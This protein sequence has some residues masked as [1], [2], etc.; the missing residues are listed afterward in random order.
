MITAQLIPVESSTIAA[1]GYDPA[2]TMLFVQF[3]LGATYSYACVTQA[4]F[5]ALMAAASK[6][7][8]FATHV[9]GKAFYP[10][11]KLPKPV[12]P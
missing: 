3:K 1:I 5:D 7:S 9:K 10:C 12:E 2:R 4:D 8:H 11:T 6:G